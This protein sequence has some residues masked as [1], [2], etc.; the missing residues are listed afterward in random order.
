MPARCKQ[1]PQSAELTRHLRAACCA[2]RLL[3][4]LFYRCQKGYS[5]HAQRKTLCCA[6]SDK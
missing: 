6:Y 5:L 3:F 2:Q 4:M 1:Q